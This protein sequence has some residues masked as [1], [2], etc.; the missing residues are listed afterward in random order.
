[1]IPGVEK[2]I[3]DVKAGNESQALADLLALEPEAT[4]AIT[5][6]TAG[7]PKDKIMNKIMNKISK[8]SKVEDLQTCIADIEAMIP[9]VEAVIADFKA[10]N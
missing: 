3:A 5:D 6:C 10:G 9:D 1:M 4:K 2:V 8:I 7:I